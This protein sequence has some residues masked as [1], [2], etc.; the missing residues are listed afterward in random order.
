MIDINCYL[1]KLICMLKDCFSS[2]LIY[3]GLQGS[4]LRGEATENSDIDIMVVIAD[5]SVEDLDNYRSIIRSLDSF[6]KS[7]GFVC[8]RDDLTNWNPLEICHLLHTTKDYVG[9]LSELV[10]AY[11]KDDI[12]LFIKMSVNNLYHAICHHHIH[13]EF[14]R[15][16][17][18]LCAA[19]KGVFFIL[20]NLYYL[21]SEQFI[22]T[23]NELLSLLDG[24]DL[25]VLIRSIEL[26][27]G[28]SHDYSESFELLFTWCQETLKAVV[29]L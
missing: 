1:K 18:N 22:T 23:K 13:A 17:E 24:K 4:Y 27:Q 25:A 8:S 6:D 15:D 7:C 20:Q 5:L 16:M 19:Y 2:R 10:P 21:T 14:N 26:N 29:L 28:I 11:T 3:V 12:K 9:K